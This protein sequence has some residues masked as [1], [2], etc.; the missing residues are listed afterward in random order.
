MLDCGEKTIHVKDSFDAI[1]F[2]KFFFFLSFPSLQIDED[3]WHIFNVLSI[4][5]SSDSGNQNLSFQR[6]LGDI[7]NNFCEKS[8]R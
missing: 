5:C 2:Y 3:V 6:A 7:F 1:L 8:S 4:N